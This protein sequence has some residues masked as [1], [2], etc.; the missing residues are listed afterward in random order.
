MDIYEA[1]VFP[2]EVQNLF[3]A[4]CHLRKVK[5]SELC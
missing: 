3:I 4:L 2:E 1:D 5:L